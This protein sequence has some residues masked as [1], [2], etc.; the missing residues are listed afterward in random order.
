MIQYDLINPD[1][2]CE[3]KKMPA[4]LYSANL[5]TH[6]R[7]M[8]YKIVDIEKNTHFLKKRSEKQLLDSLECGAIVTTAVIPFYQGKGGTAFYKATTE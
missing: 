1:R 8:W 3:M 4:L 7:C 2:I 6:K 5:H